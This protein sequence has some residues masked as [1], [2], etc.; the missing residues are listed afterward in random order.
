MDLTGIPHRIVL[1]ERLVGKAEY[2]GRRDEKASEVPLAEI[3][4]LVLKKL[5]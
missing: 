4:P 5:A 1:S 2:K 3:V